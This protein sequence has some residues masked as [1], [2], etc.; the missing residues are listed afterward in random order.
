MI[1][2]LSSKGLFHD[3]L[4]LTHMEYPI[5]KECLDIT[6]GM[7]SSTKMSPMMDQGITGT[8]DV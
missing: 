1:D 6:Q 4:I 7:H 8:P 2:K 5:G 3:F